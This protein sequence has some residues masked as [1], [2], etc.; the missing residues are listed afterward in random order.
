ML[1]RILDA[2]LADRKDVDQLMSNAKKTLVDRMTGADSRFGGPE[3]TTP[4]IAQSTR[5]AP[6]QVD[7]M[8]D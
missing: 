1:D 5:S 3:R 7:Y 6:G 2:N 4:V 8:D